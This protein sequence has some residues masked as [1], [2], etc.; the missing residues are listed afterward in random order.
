M[1]TKVIVTCG[2]C[3]DQ[4]FLKSFDGGFQIGTIE[5]GKVSVGNMVPGESINDG[6]YIVQNLL[7]ETREK[8]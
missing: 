7:I 1:K 2:I 6:D 4:S 3:G 8:N 5:G